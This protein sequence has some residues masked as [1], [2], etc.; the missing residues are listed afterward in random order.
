MKKSKIGL[1]TFHNVYNYGAVIQAYALQKVIQSEGLTCEIIDFIQKRQKDYTELV[2]IRNGFKRFAKTMMLVPVIKERRVR[3]DKFNKF[4]NNK[5]DLSACKYL[6]EQDILKANTIYDM[7][8]VGSD[9]VWNVK[10]DADTSAAYF[11]HFAD[12]TKECVAYAPSIGVSDYE[13]LLPYKKY[14]AKFNKISCREKGGAE[15]LSSLIGKD[16][17]VV[18]D[19]TL[20]VDKVLLE[21]ESEVTQQDRYIFYYSL[22]GFDKRQNNM[23]LLVAMAKK[24]QLELKIITPEWPFHK[25]IGKDI[26]DAGPEDF[27]TLIRNASIVCTNS[28][29]GTALAL[30]FERPLFVLENKNI[31]DE[32]KRSVL[33]QVGAIERVISK[34]EDLDKFET[35]EMDY[36][37]VTTKL[38]SLR[39]QSGDYLLNALNG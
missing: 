5:M 32:R 25:S 23:D 7:L 34:V 15:I 8:L 1:I 18:L 20:L 22:D 17:P 2:S 37:S 36:S 35:Y 38:E 13:D 11:L 4:I 21:R 19:P 3:K 16:V 9:Q 33:E 6:N 24:Y 39:K 30:K 27:L 12:K 14:L 31:K 10:K 29:H 28:F 26:R